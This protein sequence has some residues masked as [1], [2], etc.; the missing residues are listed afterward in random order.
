M[1]KLMNMAFKILACVFSI[2]LI[3]DVYGTLTHMFYSSWFVVLADI[4]CGGL[5][6]FFYALTYHVHENFK[7]DK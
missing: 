4:L 3:V 6:I 7:E 2:K 5:S 1:T